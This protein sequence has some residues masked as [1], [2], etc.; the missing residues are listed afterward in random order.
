M[1]VFLLVT[2]VVALAVS[3]DSR[4]RRDTFNLRTSGTNLTLLSPWLVFEASESDEGEDL[5]G[6]GDLDDWIAHVY[7]GRSDRMSNLSVNRTTSAR[8][9]Q[10]LVAFTVPEYREGTDLNGDGDSLDHVLFVHDSGRG[11]TI[12]T[13][14]PASELALHRSHVAVNALEEGLD[15]NGDGDTLDPVVHV[16][17]LQSPV[18]VRRSRGGD[19]S[20]SVGRPRSP[21]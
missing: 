16:V 7:D 5:N 20:A 2:G 19:G 4:S 13:R 9:D 17:H 6:D 10:N 3:S 18:S 11:T 8:I 12:N 1:R 21:R 14:V 15:L